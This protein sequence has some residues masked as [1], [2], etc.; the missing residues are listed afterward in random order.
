MVKFNTG[1]GGSHIASDKV[2][3]LYTDYTINKYCSYKKKK[4]HF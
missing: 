2:I 3:T 1:M 4:N